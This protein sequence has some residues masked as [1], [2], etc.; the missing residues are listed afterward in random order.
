MGSSEW[1]MVVVNDDGSSEQIDKI[2]AAEEP[3]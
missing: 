3:D 2:V 1:W